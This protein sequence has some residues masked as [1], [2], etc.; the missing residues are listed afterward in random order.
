M[1]RDGEQEWRQVVGWE[2]RMLLA[3]VL[4]TLGGEGAC[5]F[6]DP[7]AHCYGLA[8]GGREWLLLGETL[9]EVWPLHKA[10]AVS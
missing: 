2:P 6:G 4:P 3:W 9:P 1:L 8:P 7:P 5:T 10:Q